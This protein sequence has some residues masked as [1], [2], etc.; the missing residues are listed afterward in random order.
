[1]EKIDSD[2]CYEKYY[3]H[4]NFP[5]NWATMKTWAFCIVRKRENHPLL[6]WDEVIHST[7]LL[8]AYQ[9]ILF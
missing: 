2:E 9:V 7:Y 3:N 4:T 5:D 8:V 6:P 1:M